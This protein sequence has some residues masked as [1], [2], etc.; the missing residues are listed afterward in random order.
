MNRWTCEQCEDDPELRVMRGNCGGAFPA[1]TVADIGGQV[2]DAGTFVEVASIVTPIGKVAGD[3]IEYRCRSCPVA[4]A[5][6][7][8]PLISL[9][10]AS[11]PHALGQ[12]ALAGRSLTSAAA[13]ALVV[14]ADEHEAMKCLHMEEATERATRAS[15]RR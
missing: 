1:V 7:L 14:I 8:Q 11:R 13:D 9:Y 5:R 3:L 6:D 10:G 2:D 15:R 12:H 4:C